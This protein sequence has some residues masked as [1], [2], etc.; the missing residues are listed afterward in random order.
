MKGSGL[1]AF[2]RLE[3]VLSFDCCCGCCC[4]GATTSAIEG[5]FSAARRAQSA[6]T[7]GDCAS[8]G[9]WRMLN[10]RFRRMGHGFPFCV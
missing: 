9:F 10:A 8:T 4:S 5:D 3:P 2:L 6:R 1:G 7:R